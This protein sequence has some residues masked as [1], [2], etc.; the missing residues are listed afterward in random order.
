MLGDLWPSLS[1]LIC[2]MGRGLES[3]PLKAVLGWNSQ[4]QGPRPDP[5]LPQPR[6]DPLP[7]LHPTSW[8]PGR[9]LLA[10]VAGESRGRRGDPCEP[11][12]P[13]A[14]V[15]TPHLGHC[16]AVSKGWAREPRKCLT[17]KNGPSQLIKPQRRLGRCGEEGDARA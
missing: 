7:A 2:K 6:P 4:L 15:S 3:T 12:P 13:C 16:Q 10:S 11:W 14:A 9:S 5:L 1:F 8:P 17:L